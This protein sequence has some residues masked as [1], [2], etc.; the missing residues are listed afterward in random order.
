MSGLLAEGQEEMRAQWLRQVHLQV[1]PHEQ[2]E[3]LIANW[4]RKDK[5]GKVSGEKQ[6][7]RRGRGGKG[8]GELAGERSGKGS[9]RKRS[10]WWGRNEKAR[11]VIENDRHREQRVGYKKEKTLVVAH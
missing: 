5:E 4:L 6:G 7:D 8:I 2:L 3:D 11:E 10:D 9:R 1:C